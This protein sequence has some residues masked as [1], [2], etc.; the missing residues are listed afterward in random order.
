MTV[1]NYMYTASFYKAEYEDI[2]RSLY[3]CVCASSS[4]MNVSAN[5]WQQC[6]TSDKV[7]TKVKSGVFPRHSVY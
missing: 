6:M 3:M 1:R 7:I 4:L 2:K 5:N